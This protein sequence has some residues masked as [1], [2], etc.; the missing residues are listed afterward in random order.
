[1]PYRGKTNSPAYVPFVAAQI[2]TTKGLSTE[3]VARATTANVDALFTRMA[4]VKPQTG[5]LQSAAAQVCEP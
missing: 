3:E 4:V 1:V 2:A 5:Q